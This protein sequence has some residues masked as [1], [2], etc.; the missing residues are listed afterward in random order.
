MLGCRR[1]RRPAGTSQPKALS[2]EKARGSRCRHQQTCWGCARVR[3]STARASDLGAGGCYIDTVTPFPVGTSVVLNLASEH[4]NV[5]AM[6]NVVYAH[7]GMGMGLAF[8]EM[9]PTQKANLSAWLCELSGESPKAA[10]PSEA[11]MPY[12]Q[13]ATIREPVAGPAGCP[14]GTCVVAGE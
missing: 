3:A 5:H 14:A 11:D 4:H 1:N 10:A 9:T 13:E 2:R 7:T 12:L 6:A 8:A